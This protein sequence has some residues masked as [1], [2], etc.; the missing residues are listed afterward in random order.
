MLN[1]GYGDALSIADIEDFDTEPRSDGGSRS[2]VFLNSG[3]AVV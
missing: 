3:T 2:V 1:L